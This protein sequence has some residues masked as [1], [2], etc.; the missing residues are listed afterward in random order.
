LLSG[1]GSIHRGNV[2]AA[3][4]AA[5]AAAIVATNLLCER[6]FKTEGL[7][8]RVLAVALANQ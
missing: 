1:S 2:A 7:F 5:A 3:A 8:C 6:L 4:A